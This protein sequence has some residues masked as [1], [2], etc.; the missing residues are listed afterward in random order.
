MG[1][2]EPVKGLQELDQDKEKALE[3]IRHKLALLPDLPGCYLMKNS[4]GTIIYVGKAKVLKNR[5]RSYLRAA[6][7]AKP[8]GLSQKS[9]IL[10]IS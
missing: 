2:D 7:T 6:T 9:V 10:N 8:S 5:V 4:K 1:M 3:N